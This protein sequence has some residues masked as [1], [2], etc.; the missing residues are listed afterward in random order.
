MTPLND[1]TTLEAA[2]RR[3]AAQTTITDIHTHLFPPSHGQLLLW[4]ADEILT[5]HYLVAETFMVADMKLTP[6]DFW[7]LPKT[8]QADIVWKHLFL[9]RGPLSEA[10]RGALTI[11]NTLGLDTGRRDLASIR[12]WFAQQTAESYL[13]KVFQLANVNYA[14]MTNNP[15]LEQ[16]VQCFRQP[17]PIP[18][19]LK[20]ALRIDT[21]LLN[22]PAAAKAMK[23]QGYKVAVAKPDAKSLAAARAFLVEWAKKIK[24]VYMA[25]SMPPE[26]TY[27]DRGTCTTILEKVVLP[28]AKELNLP[29]AMMIGV[30]KAVNPAL[31]D[32]GDAVGTADMLAVHRLCQRHPD[33]KFLIT[34]LS[35]NNQHELA[36]LGRKFRNLHIFGCWWFCNIP[37]LIDSITRLRLEELGTAFTAQHSDCRVLDQMLYKWP[38]SRGIIANVLVDKYRDQF[39]TGWRATEA[40]IQRDVR[41]IF[42]GAFEE[43]LAK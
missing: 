28:V 33:A 8:R 42:G 38:H 3:A 26:F 5:Y 11:F 10:T 18:D 16:E 24:P 32:G 40:D 37:S 4:G 19:R 34:P 41:R 15:F 14:M 13:E 27:P 12:A 21:L 20:T 1:L 9:D 31:G 6:D 25:A 43:F 17:L 23:A 39:L 36:I 2:V 22:W 7:K 35:P 29:V 30:R